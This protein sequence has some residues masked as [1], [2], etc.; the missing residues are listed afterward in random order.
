MGGGGGAVCCHATGALSR[1]P[2]E[3]G[4]GGRMPPVV[5][6]KIAS[7]SS[8]A[9]SIASL[10]S[11]PSN[12]KS[13]LVAPSSTYWTASN[14]AHDNTDPP[15]NH[16]PPIPPPLPIVRCLQQPT[17]PQ[18][19]WYLQAVPFKGK[20][21]RNPH[22]MRRATGMGNSGGGDDGGDSC[23]VAPLVGIWHPCCRHRGICEGGEGW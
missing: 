4:R 19:Q 5:A 13:S 17:P 16:R 11:L 15:S 23:W 12:S 22:H 8:D 14:P 21:E 7:S 6:W 20:T 2:H 3:E 10:S 9:T 1:Q 18:N